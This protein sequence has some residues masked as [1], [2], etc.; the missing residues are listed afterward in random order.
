MAVVD[1]ST[2]DSPNGP[3]GPTKALTQRAS[4]STSDTYTLECD[5]KTVLVC[6]KGAGACTVTAV[7]PGSVRGAAIADPTF[8]LAAST[9]YQVIGPFPRDLYGDAN[10]KVTLSFSEVTGL[11]AVPMRLP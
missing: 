8:T 9:N 3:A 7:T 11:I 4:L 10:G 2:P 5:E 6:S 1:W